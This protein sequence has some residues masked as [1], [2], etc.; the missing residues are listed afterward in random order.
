MIRVFSTCGVIVFGLGLEPQLETH[1]RALRMEAAADRTV[2][3]PLFS[4][5]HSSPQCDRCAEDR[6]N[7]QK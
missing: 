2:D 3:S 7:K 5:L 1:Q 4:S 6:K